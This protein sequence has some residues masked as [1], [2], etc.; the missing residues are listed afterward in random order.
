LMML[1]SNRAS[2]LV[3]S[4]TTKMSIGRSFSMKRIYKAIVLSGKCVNERLKV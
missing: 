2:V 1:F 3:S 4:S